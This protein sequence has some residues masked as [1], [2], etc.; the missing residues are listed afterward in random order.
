MCSQPC[1][2]A[3]ACPIPAPCRQCCCTNACHPEPAALQ[4]PPVYADCR[5][6]LPPYD[7]IRPALLAQ[8]SAVWTSIH[9][10]RSQEVGAAATWAGGLT[11]CD[12]T[13]CQHEV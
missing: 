5:D 8:M 3:S 6:S 7:A 11:A 13:V 12:S 9:G 1:P 4:G 10:R 2:T